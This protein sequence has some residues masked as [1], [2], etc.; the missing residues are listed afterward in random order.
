MS[1]MQL[2]TV[3]RSLVKPTVDPTRFRMA[4]PG[5]LPRFGPS[6]VSNPAEGGEDHDPAKGLD[7]V[8]GGGRLRRSIRSVPAENAMSGRQMGG[9]EVE[10]RSQVGATSRVSRLSS[11]RWSLSQPTLFEMPERPKV[12]VRPGRLKVDEVRVVRNDLR[13]EDLELKP[14]SR[15]ASALGKEDRKGAEGRSGNRA[16]RVGWLGKFLVLCRL[17]R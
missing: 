2:L 11:G 10:A 13:D 1:L 5:W 16:S 17:G 7:Q 3:G 6:G 8:E 15:P 12:V 14:S 9:S 4:D